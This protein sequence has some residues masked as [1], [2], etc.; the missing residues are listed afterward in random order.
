MNPFQLPGDGRHSNA[1]YH[2]LS[3]DPGNR[4][5]PEAISLKVRAIA[6]DTVLGASYRSSELCRAVIG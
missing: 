5:V 1:I 3:F 6:G 4:L 2:N